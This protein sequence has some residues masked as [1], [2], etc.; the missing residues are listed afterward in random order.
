MHLCQELGEQ[1]LTDISRAFG[2]KRAGSILA[3]TKKLRDLMK[4]G[5]KLVHKVDRVNREMAI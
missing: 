2:L 3:T 5:Q 1:R 4:E